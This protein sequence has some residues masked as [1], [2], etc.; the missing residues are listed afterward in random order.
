MRVKLSTSIKYHVN[1]LLNDVFDF[2]VPRLFRVLLI[3]AVVSF[4]LGA[5][6]MAGTTRA[7]ESLDETAAREA[8]AAVHEVASPFAALTQRRYDDPQFF[9]R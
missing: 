6:V 8:T 7:A 3:T 4:L 1:S 2:V 5:G 9:T